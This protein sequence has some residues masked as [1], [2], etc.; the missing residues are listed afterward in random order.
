MKRVLAEI[1]RSWLKNA[2]LQLYRTNKYRDLLQI[3]MNIANNSK[4]YIC[5]ADFRCFVPD[6]N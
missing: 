1:G 3:T 5:C 2:R 6:Q 4:F